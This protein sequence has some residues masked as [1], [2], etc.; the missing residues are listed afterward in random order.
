MEPPLTL[1]IYTLRDSTHKAFVDTWI[2]WYCRCLV[3]F[4]VFVEFAL[5]L[6]A[7][8][9][10]SMARNLQGLIDNT[11]H[12]WASIQVKVVWMLDTALYLFSSPLQWPDSSSV[13][14]TL[15]ASSSLLVCAWS[16]G[17][18]LCL[19]STLCR[20]VYIRRLLATG[21]FELI[22]PM[23]GR[24]TVPFPREWYPSSWLRFSTCSTHQKDLSETW[25][26]TSALYNRLDWHVGF[27]VRLSRTIAGCMWF[28]VSCFSHSVS[29]DSMSYPFW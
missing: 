28:K 17:G 29:L 9:S 16:W 20:V 18:V 4:D 5:H 26:G 2:V 7:I 10:N 23:Y 12:R 3:M 13:V 6:P 24:G 27:G 1:V 21:R 15:E 11:D 8:P 22:N 25:L 14:L 19:P